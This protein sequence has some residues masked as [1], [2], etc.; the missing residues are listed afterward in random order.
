MSFKPVEEVHIELDEL[1]AD[2]EN[3]HPDADDFEPMD[4]LYLEP[5][6]TVIASDYSDP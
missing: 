6:Y 5:A 4:D 3:L 1:D 2:F